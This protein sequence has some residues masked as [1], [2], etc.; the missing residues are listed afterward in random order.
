MSPRIYGEA[1]PLIAA[2]IFDYVQSFERTSYITHGILRGHLGDEFSDE[3]IMTAARLLTIVEPPLL[4]ERYE[5]VDEQYCLLIT[6]QE[7]NE[8]RKNGSYIHAET[9]EEVVDF[10]K[11][12][13]VYYA[14]NL[15]F[16]TTLEQDGK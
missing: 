14:P 16:L 1:I 10:E 9:G 13:R 6:R 11:R 2:K 4:E 8:S 5:Y 3:N 7:I 15:K 12:I